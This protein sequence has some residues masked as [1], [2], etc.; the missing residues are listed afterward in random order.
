M[1]RILCIII[2]VAALFYEI[3]LSLAASIAKDVK[4]GNRLY[5]DEK[6]DEAIRK[7]NEA[8]V[9]SPDSNIVNFNVGTTLYKKG[10]YQKAVDLLTKSLITKDSQ[11]EARANYNIGSSRVR[12]G[13]AKENTDLSEAINLYK[14][15]LNYYK[16]AVDLDEKDED[17]KFNYEF[18]EK[19]IKELMEKQQQQQQQQKEQ[20]QQ[21]SEKQDKEKQKQEEE[22]QKKEQQEDPK[23]KEK[24]KQEEKEQK[25]KEQ[26]Q[27]EKEKP[28]PSPG[29]VPQG[30]EEEP[31]REGEA[32]EIPAELGEM[33]EEEAR[34]LLESYQQEEEAGDI[35][36]K[37]RKAHYP[38]VLRDW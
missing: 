31:G 2:F 7:Y 12:Q 33:S 20:Q 15:A 37:K 27:K 8:Q 14:E 3:P 9:E 23:E 25:Q 16:R 1:R 21:Q 6:Y 28:Q 36:A 4:E 17:A 35:E 18:V 30:K 11:L 10:D 19:K 29:Q 26:E 38:K 34:M 22:K 5:K 32:E 24:Q 13:S